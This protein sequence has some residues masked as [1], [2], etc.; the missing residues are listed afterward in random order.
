MAMKTKIL[1][2]L[3]VG[4]LGMPVLSGAAPAITFTGGT[5]TTIFS[6]RTLGFNFFTRDDFVI[7]SL[8]VWDRGGDGLAESHEVG[9]WSADGST[10]LMSAIVPGGTTASL[11][12]GF[13]FVAIS[14]VVL[15]GASEFLAGSSTGTGVDAVIRF[16]A[17]TTVSGI[18][19]GSTRFDPP[20]CGA[21]CAPLRTQGTTFDDGYF[22]P[23]FIGYAAVPEPGTLALLG[24][25]LA[26]LGLSRRRRAT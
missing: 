7:T 9:I 8:G 2:L 23:N 15:P 4:L 24:L 18:S 5:A 10:L 25:G 26:G 6:N 16:S 19:L 14:P 12:S 22:G 20:F 11:D 1:G 17:A 13:R 3:T 21:F